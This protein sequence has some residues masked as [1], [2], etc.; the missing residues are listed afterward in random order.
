MPSGAVHVQNALIAPWLDAPEAPVLLAMGQQGPP[1][2]VRTKR[3][4]SLPD[5]PAAVT[6]PILFALGL[7]AEGLRFSSWTAVGFAAIL[8]G[9][10]LLVTVLI[11]EL[12]HSLAARRLGGHAE[13]I[14]L[15][16]LGGLAYLAHS[17]GPKG[18]LCLRGCM[19]TSGRAALWR[20]MLASHSHQ[21]FGRGLLKQGTACQLL[22][23]CRA[24]CLLPNFTL[25]CL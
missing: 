20:R 17:S 25:R 5:A 22:L 19:H 7:L 4:P 12:G 3:H 21:H 18:A 2:D 8:Y 23:G 16:P 1:G 13:G 6:F 14:L 11:H 10:L 9:P 24:A 15:W